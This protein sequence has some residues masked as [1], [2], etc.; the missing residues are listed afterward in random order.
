[1]KYES[2]RTYNAE[3]AKKYFIK[4]ND[5]LIE[6][7][8][9]VDFEFSTKERFAIAA[10]GAL[11]MLSGGV[12]AAFNAAAIPVLPVV[13]AANCLLALTVV[14]A[15]PAGAV[16]AGMKLYPAARVE[17]AYHRSTCY[18]LSARKDLPEPEELTLEAYTKMDMHEGAKQAAEGARMINRAIFKFG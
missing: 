13:K 10:D 2:Y 7:E 14:G 15:L 17:S 11:N 6:S 16:Y 1:M 5:K 12:K 3:V 9:G 8:L 18:P 4:H